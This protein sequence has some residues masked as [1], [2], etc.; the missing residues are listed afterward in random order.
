MPEASQEDGGTAPSEIVVRPVVRLRDVIV[1]QST[2]GVQWRGR[3][4]ALA[5]DLAALAVVAAAAWLVTRDLPGFRPVYL[6]LTAALLAGAMSV[7][8]GVPLYAGVTRRG[9]LRVGSA[10]V[11]VFDL[12]GGRRSD[13]DVEVGVAWEQVEQIGVFAG[14]LCIL[15]GEV[16]SAGF[17]ADV[18]RAGELDQLRAWHRAAGDRDRAVQRTVVLPAPLREGLDTAAQASA[19]RADRAGRRAARGDLPVIVRHQYLTAV[20]RRALPRALRAYARVPWEIDHVVVLDRQGVCAADPL[21]F[22]DARWRGV[23]RVHV[24]ADYVSVVLRSG[25][26]RARLLARDQ[27]SLQDVDQIVEWARTCGV[28]VTGRPGMI[29]PT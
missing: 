29:A 12:W 28:R 3:L 14:V 7:R 8:L 22:T 17:S 23:K 11:W 21:W 9:D 16:D 4:R 19:E 20:D 2:F 6:V 10:D 15:Y 5:R 25:A 26:R 24:T 1:F 27:M 13:G 18:L